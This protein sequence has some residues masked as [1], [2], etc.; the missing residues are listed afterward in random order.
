[1]TERR[2]DI[3]RSSN[4]KGSGRGGVHVPPVTAGSGTCQLGTVRSFIQVKIDNPH[5]VKHRVASGGATTGERRVE[6]ELGFRFL[7]PR[8]EP[9]WCSSEFP[10]RWLPF[11]E[12]TDQLAENAN[13]LSAALA[14]GF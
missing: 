6:R 10:P 4:A 5:G 8:D 9:A 14:I 13:N 1:M 7:R 3:C 11:G 12:R 2:R